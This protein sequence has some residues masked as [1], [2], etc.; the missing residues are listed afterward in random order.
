M[1]NSKGEAPS[2][3]P[4]ESSWT[5]YFDDFLLHN[6]VASERDH[7]HSSFSSG[8][9][10]S[11]LISDAGSSVANK[12]SAAQQYNDHE[13]NVRLSVDSRRSFKKRK[14]KAAP[15]PHHVVHDDALE[16]TATSTVCNLISQQLETKPKERGNMDMSHEERGNSSGHIN[17][18]SDQVGFVERESDYTGLKKKGLC[19]VPLSMV[20]NYLR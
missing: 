17:E 10:T 15:A 6:S 20:V 18:K 5:M 8:C 2:A 14:T 16:D 11:S 1:E 9:E 7:Q 12:N 4:E 19:L 13:I 3:M